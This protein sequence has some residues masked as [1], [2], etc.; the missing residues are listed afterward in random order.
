MLLIIDFTYFIKVLFIVFTIFICVDIY[1]LSGVCQQGV[2]VGF[3]GNYAT[4]GDA[5]VSALVPICCPI[6]SDQNATAWQA[7]Y[8]SIKKSLWGE[9]VNCSIGEQLVSKYV[10][11]YL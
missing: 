7:D 2:L 3:A 4:K 9:G 10:L 5:A 1:Y 6:P 11:F 8:G